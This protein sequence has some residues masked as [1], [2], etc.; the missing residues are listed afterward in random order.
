MGKLAQLT[1]FF[2]LVTFCGINEAFTKLN[3]VVSIEWVAHH[4]HNFIM[5]MIGK[6][7]TE[8]LGLLR[9]ESPRWYEILNR[10]RQTQSY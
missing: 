9:H 10:I 2:D 5:F 4:W 7:C 3:L 1:I 6:Q 8:V